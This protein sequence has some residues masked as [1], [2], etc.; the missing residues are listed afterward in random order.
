VTVLTASPMWLAVGR[1]FRA[2]AYPFNGLVANPV[3]H[4]TGARG[5]GS[6]TTQSAKEESLPFTMPERRT[7]ESG[8]VANFSETT[9]D[10]VPA[11]PGGTP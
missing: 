11:A 3:R 9:G 1:A 6:S 7:M 4:R 8:V 10:A 5:G 2:G